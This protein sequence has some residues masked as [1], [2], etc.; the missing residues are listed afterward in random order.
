[1]KFS[2]VGHPFYQ[3]LMLCISLSIFVL[4]G[5]SSSDD[6]GT[7]YVKFYN[8]SPNA[9]GIFLTVDEN[10]DDDD[11]D[12]IEVTYSSVDFTEVSGNNALDTDTYFIELAWQDE[13]SSDRS[14]LEIIYED[15]VKIKSDTI[16]FVAL[17]GDVREPE[18]LRFDIDVV[19]DDDDDDDDLFN[20]RLLN[21]HAD[22]QE[23]DVYVSKDN[24]TFNEAEFLATASYQDLSD[25][26]KLEQDQYIFY[27]TLPG[28]TDV[29]Y[30]SVD[31]SYS[32]VSQYIIVLR[33]NTGVGSSDFTIDSIGINGI[34]E[35]QDVDSEAEFGFYN[36]ISSNDYLPDYQG[37]IDIDV[38]IGSTIKVEIDDLVKG[39]FSESTITSN[40]D[41]AFD[42]LNS[43]TSEL[44]IKDALLSL[45]ENADNTIFLYGRKDA[46]DDD[47]DGDID[48]N[49]DGIVDDY[50]IVIKSLTLTKSSSSSIYSHGVK[51]VNLANSE[52][53]S[54]V[55]FYFVLNDE[56]ISTADNLLSV[57]QE[58]S[59]SLTLLN[60]TYDIYAIA[61]IDGTDI[62]LDSMQMVLNETSQ[63]QYL[64][65][66]QDE[67]ASSGYKML[68][69]DQ[70]SVD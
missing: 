36:A 26:M 39:E 43:D 30:T 6:D 24:E 3:S 50:E 57:L 28:S 60:N 10:L 13:E 69:V 11:D 51:V 58:N 48:E 45:Q 52:D 53:F 46:I 40:G 29:I 32:V 25:N 1:M 66:E 56:I 2:K 14:D 55:T 33:D 8:A 27:I 62:V 34:T 35:L 37:K 5:C 20:V 31:Q 47:E 42:V 65:F 38:R 23:V 70:T 12:E 19:D 63:E 44:Y 41:Y 54:R 22:I 49:G 59:G 67:N 21:I 17:T 9:P 61:A 68:L 15:S 16:S 18:V 7:G 64:I 4:A